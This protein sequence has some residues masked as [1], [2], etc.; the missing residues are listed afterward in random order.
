MEPIER[1]EEITKVEVEVV[2][3]LKMIREAQKE[4]FKANKEYANKWPKLIAFVDTGISYEIQR[5]EIVTLRDITL[6]HLGDSVRV[7]FDTLSS[8]PVNEKLFPKAKYPNFDVNKLPFVPEKD[9]MFNL[10]AEESS[11]GGVKI[12]VVEVMDPKPEDKSRKKDHEFKNK[13]NLYF[14]SREKASLDG[15]WKERN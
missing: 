8:T 3:Q 6:R 4:Y 12:Q 14:G 15:N 9:F 11:M 13:R 2:K 7:E 10:F 1:Q 5:R